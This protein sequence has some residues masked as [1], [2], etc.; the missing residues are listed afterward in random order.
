MTNKEFQNRKKEIRILIEQSAQEEAM[1]L[2]HELVN[3]LHAQ[4]EYEKIV[5][6]YRS[7]L[8]ESKSYLYSFE[9][10]YALVDQN[11]ENEAEPIYEYIVAVNPK[12]SAALNNLSNIKKRKGKIEEAFD[13]IQR[14]YEIEPDDDIISDNYKS[15]SSLIRAKEE[16]DLNFKHALTY[17]PKENDFVLG[18]LKN[19]IG[20][21]K[22]DCDFEKHII[23][24]P[25]WKFKILMGTDEQKSLFLLDQWLEKG[26]LRKT[27]ERGHYQELVY[28]I[29]PFLEK[30]I[31]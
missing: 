19:F 17:L 30:G 22:K 29:N 3:E 16:I 20:N 18:K 31:R 14:A 6:L 12:N 7:K 8:I 15:L 9:V 27:D 2:A 11:R 4:K 23:P 25:R 28:E 24:I 5:E 26:Y 1:E 10:A 13:L 21:V